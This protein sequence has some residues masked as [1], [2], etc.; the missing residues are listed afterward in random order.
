MQSLPHLQSEQAGLG[1]GH[2]ARVVALLL[3]EFVAALIQGIDLSLALGLIIV[4]LLYAC[5]N[6]A[7]LRM[8]GRIGLQSFFGCRRHD[9]IVALGY[10]RRY[11]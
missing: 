9:C 6:C 2:G 7:G 3:V 11:M 10:S 1:A 4:V 8:T 5:L